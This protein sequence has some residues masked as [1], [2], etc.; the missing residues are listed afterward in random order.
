MKK[1]ILGM[2]LVAL[3]LSLQP[4]SAKTLTRRSVTFEA[5]VPCTTLCAYNVDWR[6]VDD[7]AVA[8]TKGTQAGPVY[9]TAPVRGPFR[10][11]SPQACSNPF[12]AGSYDDVVV[13]APRY[14]RTLVFQIYP[15][16][17]WDSFICSKP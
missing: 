7:E 16:V 8:E 6:F 2:T 4:A 13:T 10:S 5:A 11:T 9:K 17:D 3:A 1:M 12:P 14:S 15:S